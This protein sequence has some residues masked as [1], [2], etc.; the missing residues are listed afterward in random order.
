MRRLAFLMALTAG[1][2]IANAD[3]L[4]MDVDRAHVSSEQMISSLRSCLNDARKVLDSQL[5]LSQNYRQQVYLL[6]GTMAD[7][8]DKLLRIETLVSPGQPE[9]NSLSIHSSSVLDGQTRITLMGATALTEFKAEQL[10]HELKKLTRGGPNRQSDLNNVVV[11]AAALSE[12]IAR[13]NAILQH[14]EALG[15]N[16][17]VE[18][19][20]NARYGPNRYT[21]QTVTGDFTQNNPEKDDR[22]VFFLT[23]SGENYQ[24]K[25][26]SSVL[27]RDRKFN[28]DT[29]VSA[30]A[31]KRKMEQATKQAKALQEL[32][33]QI[34]VE[35]ESLKI[36]GQQTESKL[37]DMKKITRMWQEKRIPVNS[38]AVALENKLSGD[39]ATYLDTLK[40]TEELKQYLN[41][42][43]NSVLKP[44]PT[45]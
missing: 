41:T 30:E 12:Q 33:S 14:P 36:H 13:I 38:E 44:G 16:L 23:A 17:L 28:P 25:T 27:S 10:S 21:G 20:F 3:G 43:F 42:L 40:E 22:G 24:E 34:V 8:E 19:E 18:N 7:I 15:D 31:L 11:K 37:N 4:C 6:S 2:L 9:N 26:P 32:V 45:R 29:P 35:T 1:V 39:V 5:D